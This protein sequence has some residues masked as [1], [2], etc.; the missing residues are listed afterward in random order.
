M[1]LGGVI[2]QAFG[3]RSVALPRLAL[4]GLLLGFSCGALLATLSPAA[5]KERKV[6]TS[7]RLYISLNLTYKLYI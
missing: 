1:G 6:L 3:A 5:E 7:P 4:Q 2:A